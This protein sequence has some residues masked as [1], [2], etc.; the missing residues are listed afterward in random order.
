MT[1]LRL[2]YQTVEFGKTDIHLCGLRN[3]QEF[4]DPDKIAENM[5][6]SSATWPIFGLLWPS[7]IVLAKFLYDF[8]TDNKRVLEVGCGLALSSLLLNKRCEDITATDYHPEVGT[9]LKRNALLNNDPEI[10]FERVDWADTTDN[11]GEF[12]LIIGSDV[13][14]EDDHVELL[15]RFIEA[16]AC[17]KCQIIIVDPSRGRKTKFI[18]KLELFG[19]KTSIEKV[20]KS[21]GVPDNYKGSL[22]S[23]TR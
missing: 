21:P 12:D 16:H 6:I 17:E 5:G 10:P 1:S 13:L 4:S 22:L 14:Y 23:F 2:K 8:N 19:F 9:F 20:E 15:A 11:L 18:K 7:S 3:K